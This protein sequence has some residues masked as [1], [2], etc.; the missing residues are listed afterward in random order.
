MMGD[1]AVAGGPWPLTEARP[2][3]QAA[4]Q[5]GCQEPDPLWKGHQFLSPE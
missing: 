1:T 2:P 5:R 4:D 3:L